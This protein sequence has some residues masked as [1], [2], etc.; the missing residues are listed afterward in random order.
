[1]ISYFKI[2]P[3]HRLGAF[4][5]N[6]VFPLKHTVVLRLTKNMG[7]EAERRIGVVG[8]GDSRRGRRGG[9]EGEREGEGRRGGEVR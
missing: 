4:S 7:S 3:S 6:Y 1:M 2:R 5:R 9:T 8:G